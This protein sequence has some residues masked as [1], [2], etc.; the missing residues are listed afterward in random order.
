MIAELTPADLASVDRGA[1]MQRVE[2][3][4]NDTSRKADRILEL[5][6]I[7]RDVTVTNNLLRRQVDMLLTKHV[8]EMQRW[9]LIASGSLRG[10]SDA[11]TPGR[12]D[13][14][15]D[16]VGEGVCLRGCAWREA[17]TV[18]CLSFPPCCTTPPRPVLRLIAL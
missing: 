11:M 3:L 8:S 14:V 4:E 16:Y 15:P 12:E 17:D 5:E 10:G 1:L 9:R 18:R 7:L 13:S 6:T 2:L